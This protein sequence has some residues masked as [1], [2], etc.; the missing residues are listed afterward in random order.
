MSAREAPWWRDAV[1]YQVYL[2]SFADSDGDGTGDLRGLLGHLD[3]LA[4]LGVDALWLNPFYVSGEADAGYDVIDHRAVDPAMGTLADVDELIEQAHAR[5]LRVVGDIVANHTSAQHPWFRQARSGGPGDPMRAR[6][7]IAPGRDGA[8]PSQWQ[9]LFGGPAWEPLGDG[10]WY[11]HLFD[12]EQPDLNW[13]HPEVRADVEATVRFWLDRGFDGLRFDAAGALA[14]APGYPPAPEGERRP[15]DGHPF[16]DRPEVHRIHRRFAEILAERPARYGVAETW[17]PAW[18]GEPYIRP[19]ELQQAFAMDVVFTPLDAGALG[20]T[21]RSYLEAAA[22]QGRRPAWPHGNH[23]VTR[24]A[25]RWGSEGALAVLWLLLALPGATYL[26]AGDELALPEVELADEDLRDPSWVRSGG[27]DRGRDGARVPLPWTRE[28]EGHHGFSPPGA[29]HSPWLPQPP[30]W[31]ERS[32]RAQ[33]GDAGSALN[34]VRGALRARSGLREAPWPE[35]PPAPDGVLAFRR[36]Q[37]TCVLNSSEEPLP[38]ETW[39]GELLSSSR[40]LDSQGRLPSP[41]TAWLR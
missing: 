15:G 36:G 13:D 30:G 2:R 25:S 12:V 38:L 32:V 4:E 19:G 34:R 39:G 16:S 37:V 33:H 14:K 21:V 1:V 40:P 7:H 5:G 11:L 9:S 35:W 20:C 17:G 18:L 22:R 28:S 8:P 27:T 23:D 3:H 10:E 29:L 24:A 31:G 26:Y 41:G 6:Y